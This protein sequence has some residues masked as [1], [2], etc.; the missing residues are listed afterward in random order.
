MP[1]HISWR[2][3]VAA[4][5]L[6]SLSAWADQ[7]SAQS[8]NDEWITKQQIDGGTLVLH[9]THVYEGKDTVFR[10]DFPQRK[11]ASNSMEVEGILGN[12]RAHT[13]IALPAY[14]FDSAD[15]WNYGEMWVCFDP[16]DLVRGIGTEHRCN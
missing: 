7:S 3:I 11:D 10:I 14:G 4:T 16:S 5:L 6:F 13:R 12:P 8:N 1:E 2:L 9:W 15:S